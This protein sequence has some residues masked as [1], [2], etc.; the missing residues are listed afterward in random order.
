[1]MKKLTSLLLTL[2]MALT[3]FACAP[4]TAEETVLF[5]DDAGREVE[6]PKDITRIAATGPLAQIVLFALAPEYFVG[7]SSA[8]SKEAEEFLGDYYD[9]PVLGQLYGSADL[10]LE[11]LAA[12]DPQVIIDVGEAKGSIAED[13]DATQEQLG[14]PTVHIDAYT[15]TF[16]DAYRKLGALLGLQERAEELATYCEKVYGRAQSIMETVGEEGRVNLLYLLGE[17]GLSVIAGGSYHAEIIDM[18]ASNLAVV[19]NPSSKGSGNPVDME[20]LLLWDPDMIVFAPGSIYAAVGEDPLWQ[21]LTAIQNKNYVEVPFG[22]YN[23]MGFPPSVQRY[24]G[25]LWLT[26]LFYPDACDYDLKAEVTEYYDLFYHCEL[27]DEQ[28]GRLMENAFPKE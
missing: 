11:Q 24:L 14:I 8:W 10:N 25:I 7:T 9:L 15:D 4:A 17:D 12:V 27:T 6:V 18:L 2:A 22:P 3:L 23:W 13:M 5:T 20:Q 28:Y 16:A 21:D 26:D 19:D 1:M